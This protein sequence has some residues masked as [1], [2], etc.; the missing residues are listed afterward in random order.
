M[1]RKK[2]LFPFAFDLC[3]AQIDKIL[4][5][6]FHLETA[7]KTKHNTPAHTHTHAERDKYISENH[8]ISIMERNN[9]NARIAGE[10]YIKYS[11]YL[12]IYMPKRLGRKVD[13]SPHTHTQTYRSRR[14]H[15]ATDTVGSFQV[16]FAIW[17]MSKA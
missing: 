8:F 4:S 16:W 2:T 1:R 7:N 3:K 15:T 10:S 14:P 11:L 6:C 12:I 17:S 5:F 9:R 13:F